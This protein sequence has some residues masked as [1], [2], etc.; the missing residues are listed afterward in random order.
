MIG[1]YFPLSI[2]LHSLTFCHCLGIQIS[3]SETNYIYIKVSLHDCRFTG[4]CPGGV[5][6]VGGS[7]EAG[8]ALAWRRASWLRKAT[9]SSKK[10]RSS[11]RLQCTLRFCTLP[12]YDIKMLESASEAEP[13]SFRPPASAPSASFSSWV[14]SFSTQLQHPASAPRPHPASAPSFSGPASAPRRRPA[15]AP[16]FS[17]PASAPSFTT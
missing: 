1:S 17:G 11:P 12:I 7:C 8:C 13:L 10:R 15:S 4:N 9:R 6:G 2:L 3:T 5:G 14:P 16:S